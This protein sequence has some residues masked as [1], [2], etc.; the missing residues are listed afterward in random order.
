MMR[1]PLYRIHSSWS[2][3][4]W[5]GGDRDLLYLVSSNKGVLKHESSMSHTTNNAAERRTE[6]SRDTTRIKEARD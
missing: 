6:A 4:A 2:G 1:A 3:Y 5:E